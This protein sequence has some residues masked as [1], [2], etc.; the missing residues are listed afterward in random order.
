[1]ADKG[2]VTGMT[3]LNRQ[4]PSSPCKPC[5]EG[6]QTCE[7]IR[8]IAIMRTKHVLG[9]VH[10][11]ICG[12]LPIHSHHGYQYFVT[13]INNSSRFT[14]IYPLWEKLEVGK[15]LKAFIAWVELETRLKVKTLRSDGGGE[16]MARHVK[17]YLVECGIK[18]EVMT[19]D[20]PQHNRVTERLNRMLLDK[21]QA[22]LANTNLPKSY[23]LEALNYATFLHNL[24]PSHSISTTPSKLY[25]G[26]KLD[27]SR[28][29][30]FGC[31]AHMH[32]PEK[33][34]DK[35][36]AHSL[37]C[38]FL[39]FSQQQT[40]FHL[41]HRPS[42]RFIESYDVIFDKGGPHNSQE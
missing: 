29:C 36:S 25:T 19:P 18:H 41:M 11:D 37:S 17:D 33:S 3:V 38:I 14:S 32:I 12:P 40:A 6:K 21:A 30:V 35:L 27:V 39:G 13:F 22:M 24:S 4:V 16:Y 31:T 7:V 42:H 1:M 15:S 9:H 8:K 26:T 20:T 28:L 5:L 34:C 2:L 10:T 23:W